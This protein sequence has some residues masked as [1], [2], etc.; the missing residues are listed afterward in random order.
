M[1]GKPLT[2]S[3]Q[4]GTDVAQVVRAVR[5]GGLLEQVFGARVGQAGRVGFGADV[6]GRDSGCQ[7]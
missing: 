6:G 7:R 1:V 5:D 3:R 4:G 2:T